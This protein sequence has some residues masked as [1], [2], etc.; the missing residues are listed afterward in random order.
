ME[1]CFYFFFQAEDG[2]RDGHVTGVQTCA[3]PHTAILGIC[4][5]KI[6]CRRKKLP[7]TT[8]SKTACPGGCANNPNIGLIKTTN[9]PTRKMNVSTGSAA[10]TLAVAPSC[11]DVTVTVSAISTLRPTK[12]KGSPSTGPFV[13]PILSLGT[14]E[15][16]PLWAS[17][18]RQKA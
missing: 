2:I 9:T 5:T 6:W 4:R 15:W 12:K 18:A 13:T 3:L 16:K 10:T 7:S 1:L 11:G 8:K 14:T 17:P